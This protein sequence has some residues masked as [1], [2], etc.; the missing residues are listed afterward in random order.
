[1][2]ELH[3]RHAV[4]QVIVKDLSLCL[5][6]S[7]KKLHVIAV[8]GSIRLD[9]FKIPYSIIM[10]GLNKNKPKRSKQKPAKKDLL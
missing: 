1:M 5:D 9:V 7:N 2:D 3:L 10:K 8:G 4:G 6:F